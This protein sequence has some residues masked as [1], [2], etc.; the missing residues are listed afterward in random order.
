MYSSVNPVE[1]PRAWVCWSTPERTHDL[2]RLRCYS[3]IP[4][5]S[6]VQGDS[7]REQPQWVCKQGSKER[8]RRVT[9][10]RDD[11]D[12]NKGEKREEETPNEYRIVE[13]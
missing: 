10:N 7:Y 6:E 3:S 11:K 5:I 13:N 9:E 2:G 8:H 12:P 1:R 4:S